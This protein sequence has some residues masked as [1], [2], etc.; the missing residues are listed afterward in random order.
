MHHADPAAARELVM[1][2][3]WNTTAY[4]ILNPG[5]AHWFSPT[6]PAV[7]G[8]AA[9]RGF[10]VVAG[11]PVC[12][13][14]AA[15]RV[16]RAFEE[17]ARRRSRRVC[18]VCAEDRMHRLLT[19]SATHASVAIG[20][21]PAWNPQDWDRVVQTHASIRAQVNRSRNKGVEIE[22]MDPAIC[23]R[24]LDAVLKAWLNGRNLPV[25]HFLVEPH[26]LGG[27]VAG[28]IVLVALRG[29]SPVAFLA[30]SPIPARS[31]YLIEQIVR[32]PGA[33]NGTAELL[34]D[35]AMRR[36][37]A[38]GCTFATLGLV[39]LSTQAADS[40]RANPVWLQMLMRLAR[41]HANRFYNFR[42]LERFRLKLAPARWDTIY[43]ISNERRFSVR[44]L[45]AIGEAFAGMAVW[46]A[47]AIGAARAV[48]HELTACGL[49][50]CPSASR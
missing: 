7:V 22:A 19:G 31:G 38:L 37:A 48:R 1:A 27:G 24:T 30:A 47:L 39:A 36:F 10:Y 14:E 5:I 12:A 26:I 40:I 35:A 13:E 11:A 9:R 50:P 4:Q 34:I 3:G 43:A 28:R 44:A 23:E 8:Y 17:F 41:L 18:Y 49:L 33:P 20:A 42:G 29:G 45:Y 15:G 32:A 2:H 16:T 21:Q 25:L 46:R 6:D